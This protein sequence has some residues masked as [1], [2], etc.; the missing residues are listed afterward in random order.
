MWGLIQ[1]IFLGLYGL[2]SYYIGYRG[3][4]TFGKPTSRFLRILYWVVFSLLVLPFPVA[5]LGED[6]LPPSIV[7]WLTIWGGYSMVAVLYVFLLLLTID[8]LRLIDKWVSFVPAVIKEHKKTPLTLGALVVI[9]V[10]AI[11][12][13]GG[14]NARNP[15]VTEYDVTVDKDAGD[16]QQLQIAM[17]SDIHYGPIIDTQRL[18]RLIEMMNEIKP[19]IVLLAGDITDGSLPPGEARKLADILGQIQ[20]PY[21]TFA[22]PGNHDR[23]LRDNDSELMRY[24]KE[25]GIHVLKDNYVSVQDSFYLIGRDDPNR[26]SIPARMELEDVMI[27]IDSSKP[28]IL[29]DHQPIDLEQAQAS[30]I[31][32]QLSGHTHRGQIFPASL[33]TGLIYEL[34]WGLLKKG[35]YHLIVS[36]GYGTWGPPLRIGNQPEVVSITMTF[37]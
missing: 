25:A 34:D 3:S 21:G 35:T 30:G 32:L 12:A 24:L 18:N 17:I 20:A 7:P 22:V 27:G 37:N 19:D 10:L 26:R 15:V 1:S 16:L 36:S 4:K 31:D 28:L 33:I 13:Y 8:I 2:M 14:W 11:V 29:L 5:E 9:L 6:V 23:D